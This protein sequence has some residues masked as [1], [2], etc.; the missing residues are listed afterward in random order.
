V[1]KDS[2]ILKSPSWVV[3]IILSCRSIRL[4]MSTNSSLSSSLS[5]F[6]RRNTAADSVG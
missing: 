4:S 3:D 1:L 6:I 5:A 2:S